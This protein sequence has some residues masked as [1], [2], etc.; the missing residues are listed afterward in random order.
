MLKLDNGAYYLLLSSCV[1]ILTIYS[2]TKYIEMLSTF[3]SLPPFQIP[4]RL[5]TVGFIPLYGGEETHKVLALFA[6]EDSLAGFNF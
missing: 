5:S 2:K 1:T 3:V 4:I 6:P